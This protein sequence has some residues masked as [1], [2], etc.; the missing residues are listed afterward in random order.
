MVRLTPW[1]RRCLPSDEALLAWFGRPVKK[2]TARRLKK[3]RARFVKNQL[4]CTPRG[5]DEHDWRPCPSRSYPG[6]SV[7]ICC[8]CRCT[9]T[10]YPE[11]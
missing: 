11:F 10:P 9:F 7:E 5:F 8:R 1:Q 4:R 2:V 6:Y 3:W